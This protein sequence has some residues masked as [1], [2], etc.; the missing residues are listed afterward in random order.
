M[1][2]I[3]PLIGQTDP[4]PAPIPVDPPPIVSPVSPVVAKIVGPS[5]A[6]AGELVVLSS[7]GSMGDNVVWVRPDTIQTVQAG[8]SILDTQIFFST[9]KPGK[10]EFM[11]IAADKTAAI[12]YAKHTV[13]IGKPVVEPPPV[14]PPPVDPPP[15][16]PA[17]W[18]GL[19][20][21]SKTS[22]DKLN[23]VQTRSKLKAAIAAAVIDIEEKSPPLAE[24][25]E[26]VKRTIELT[27]LARTGKSQ[28]VDWTMWRRGNQIELDRVGLVDTK[29]YIGAVKAIAAGL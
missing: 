26:Q 7:T 25:K 18:A 13:T 14:D 9:T 20:D 1:L 6:P 4:V 3:V 12:A 24:A 5:V 8:C 11:L 28:L 22:A 21:I 15:P 2:F 29:D 19:V 27:L 23:D 16:N 17:K 10:Y